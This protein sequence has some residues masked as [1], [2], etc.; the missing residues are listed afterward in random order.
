MKQRPLQILTV[1]PTP[2]PSL[3]ATGVVVGP[4]GPSGTVVGVMTEGERREAMAAQLAMQPQGRDPYNAVPEADQVAAFRGRILGMASRSGATSL[5]YAGRLL[6]DHGDDARR[7]LRLTYGPA[8]PV[9]YRRID[10]VLAQ[11]GVPERPA[12]QTEAEVE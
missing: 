12:E 10:N 11:A 6:R 2:G 7:Q 5:I 9:S 8:W 1:A 4:A 3:I